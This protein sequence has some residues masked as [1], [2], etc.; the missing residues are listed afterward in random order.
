M[1]PKH[2]IAAFALLLALTPAAS[3]DETAPFL[4]SKLELRYR[5][6]LQVPF[7]RG[8]YQ[9]R[10]TFA[11]VGQSG[12]F[13]TSPRIVTI[14][15]EGYVF[16]DQSGEGLELARDLLVSVSRG[17]TGHWA[18]LVE[19]SYLDL[20]QV[21]AQ[22]AVVAW[23]GW[24]SKGT[25]YRFEDL[26]G[27]GQEYLLRRVTDVSDNRT[28]YQ[29]ALVAGT[30]GTVAKLD[31]ISYNFYDPANP[32]ATG[33]VPTN[34]TSLA[35]WIKFYYDAF[36]RIFGVDGW[37]MSASGSWMIHGYR[38]AW[39]SSS[40]SP[41]DP[42]SFTELTQGS[43]RSLQTTFEYT[44]GLISAVQTPRGARYAFSRDPSNTS[45]IS[46]ITVSG[47]GLQTATTTY[48]Y[49]PPWRT[50]SQDS[51]TRIVKT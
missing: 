38:I 30:A 11:L 41:T 12:A 34:S 21:T 31:S 48:W 20:V 42:V 22:A 24:D 32:D 17:G 45:R 27:T 13:F 14:P 49:D 37:S 3:A 26:T 4:N 2:V 51:V 43:A 46:S 8:H 33:P 44:G 9:P 47:P 28:E 1:N 40:S 23:D 15:G 5:V 25:H 29:Y 7:A 39:S 50:F 6:S 18:V 10:V 16:V 36:G 35:S 19:N